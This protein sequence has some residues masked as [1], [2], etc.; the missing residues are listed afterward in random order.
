MI[1]TRLRLRDF[2]SYAAADVAF[3]EGLTV[4][5]GRNGAGKTNLLEALYF[6]C[7]GRSCRTSN[8]REVVRF[9]ATAARVEVDGHDPDGPHALSV[10]F[11]PGEA[12]RM[13]VDGA[14]VERMADAP[15]RPLVSVFLPDRL[16]LVK[17]APA[18]RR[19][20]VDQV[21]AALW[22]ARADT[23]RAYSAALAQ[24]NALLQRIRAGRAN[25]ASLPAWDAELAR[26]GVALRD[27]RARAVELLRER[28]ATLAGELGLAGTAGA[29]F[30]PRTRAAT[31]EAF[32]AELAERVDGDLERGFTGHGPHRDDL[33]LERDGRD[34][35]AYGSQGEQRLALLALLIAEREALAEARGRPPLLLLDDVMSELDPDRR[36]RLAE[37]IARHGQSVVTT[38]DLAHVPGASSGDVTR[39]AVGEGTVLQEA[40][41]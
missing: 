14:P 13:R 31:P 5:H 16:E 10:G 4:L 35:R 12:K 18:L 7:T 1:V 34:L 21:V 17:G 3:G 2:R 28:F 32:A 20:H 23:R 37:R 26:H 24:R 39:V 36:E 33:V 41:A 19:A 11:Q 27:D 38:T 9:G 29:R 8:E 30:R 15:A 22:P 25:R 6:G 40:A